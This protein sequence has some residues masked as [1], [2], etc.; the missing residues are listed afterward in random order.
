MKAWNGQFV[1]AALFSANISYY[2]YQMHQ[3]LI[4]IIKIIKIIIIIIIIILAT[5]SSRPIRNKQDFDHLEIVASD[6]YS[7]NC[8]NKHDGTIVN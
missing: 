2:L 7:N 6:D 4:K 1:D 8:R 3:Y 5:A